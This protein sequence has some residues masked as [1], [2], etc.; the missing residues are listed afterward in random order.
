MITETEFHMGRV[1]LTVYDLD[2]VGDYYERVVGLARI[3]REGE[4]ATYGAGGRVL[5][6]LRRDTAARQRSQREAG[7]F[8]AAFLMPSR[9]DLGRWTRY[10]ADNRIPVV[11]VSDHAVSEAIYL[12]DPEG[13]GIEVY[14]DRPANSWI[15][16]NG[17][18]HMV[19]EAL[20]VPDLVASAGDTQWTGHAEGMT[21]GHV[22][23]Q[24]GALPPAEAFYQ[25][26]I[27]L[28]VTTHYPGATFYSANGYHHHIATNQWNSRG[29]GVR[30]FPSTGLSE[31]EM[32]VAPARVAAIR[33][34]AEAQ[35]VALGGEGNTVMLADPWGTPVSL[36]LAQ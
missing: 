3:S 18:V 15:W 33:A 28:D 24:V 32:L 13:N 20:D 35:G 27:G 2:R 9:A 6:E 21:M 17:S 12:T 26:L 25:G 19:T 16:N 8:H 36:K 34:A 29:A 4:V 7:L 14:A 31:V 22:H 11:G 30:N 1:A 10:I 23:L 5:L